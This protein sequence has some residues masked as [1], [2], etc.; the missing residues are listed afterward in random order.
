M[1][2]NVN[3]NF[4]ELNDAELKLLCFLAYH[5]EDFSISSGAEYRKHVRVNK[6]TYDETI[7]K[8]NECGFIQGK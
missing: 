6:K 7:A 2:E 5:G 1:I 3:T 8:L 4:T